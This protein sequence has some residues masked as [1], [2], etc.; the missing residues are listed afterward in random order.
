MPSKPSREERMADL[1]SVYREHHE[2]VWRTLYHF[3][4]RSD[5]IRDA[6]QE[7][8]LVVHR[9]LS[10]F[11]GRTSLR[12]WLYGVARRVAAD[13]RKK[14]QRKTKRLQLVPD[15]DTLPCAETQHDRIWA[16]D[17]VR[18][19]LGVLDDDKRQAFVLAE[20]EGMTVPEIAHAIGV[21]PNTVYA[22][23]RAARQRFQREIERRRAVELGRGQTCNR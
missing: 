21:N 4:L 20:V 12:N 14:A 15:L 9:K 1:E 18:Q 5:E 19:F 3:G 7:V 13:H 16:G 6:Q 23:L 17:L 11:D 10:S 2:F 22:R 8:F